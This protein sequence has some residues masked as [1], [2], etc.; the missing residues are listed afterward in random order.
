[1]FKTVLEKMNTWALTS[2]LRKAFS[3]SEKLIA[4]EYFQHLLGSSEKSSFHREAGN[5]LS[6]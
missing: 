5:V 2:V 1:M 4:V 6:N 3:Q